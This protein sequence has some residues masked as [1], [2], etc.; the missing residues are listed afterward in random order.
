[1]YRINSEIWVPRPL[2]EVFPFFADAKNLQE[3]TPAWLDFRVVGMS[4]PRIAQG[5]RIDYRLK[6]RGIPVKWQSE[7]EVWDPPY[8]FVDR[9][10][11]GPYAFWHHE[12]I[13]EEQRGGT[14]CLDRVQYS[15]PGGRLFA[16]II[17]RIAVA[18]DVQKIFAYRRERLM[19]LFPRDNG[20]AETDR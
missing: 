1:M 13:F 9:Q 5:T 10:L 3:I 6:I 17:N 11:A 20:T 15:P 8:R 4:T 7:I 18:G 12:H 2:T 19:L 16:P 14:L